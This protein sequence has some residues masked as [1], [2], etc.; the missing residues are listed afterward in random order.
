MH[1]DAQFDPG[2][3]SPV[4]VPRPSVKSVTRKREGIV[5]SLKL[6]LAAA[7]CA[8][9]L[10]PASALAQQDYDWTG[11]YVG[12]NLGASWGDT[13]HCTRASIKVSALMVLSRIEP[14]PSLLT[15]PRLPMRL[16]PRLVLKPV[17]ACL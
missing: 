6:V 12:G 7:G 1:S 5:M 2:A 10:A 17:G 13:C 9:L 4:A 8:S 3:P 15:M 11:F 14:A 16:M